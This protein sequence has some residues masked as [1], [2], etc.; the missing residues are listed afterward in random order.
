MCVRLVSFCSISC[1]DRL[2]ECYFHKHTTWSIIYLSVILIFFSFLQFMIRSHEHKWPH[3]LLF[4]FFLLLFTV[5]H[6]NGQFKQWFFFQWTLLCNYCTTTPSP[7]LNDR[8]IY[9]T[10][11]YN[12]MNRWM[13]W[14]NHIVELWQQQK[15]LLS[16]TMCKKKK[17]QEHGEKKADPLVV[18]CMCVCVVQKQI[19]CSF[20]FTFNRSV[21]QYWS[22]MNDLCNEIVVCLFVFCIFFFVFLHH[23]L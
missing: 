20:H 2:V 11:I 3:R 15:K 14:Q 5:F 18:A 16:I 10:C 17:F 8:R 6:S 13:D 4:L 22:N 21:Y 23:P 12:R 9:Y 7:L 1:F 19:F